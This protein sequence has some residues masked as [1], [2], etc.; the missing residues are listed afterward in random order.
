MHLAY[1]FLWQ[2]PN[3]FSFPY[4]LLAKEEMLPIG[5]FVTSGE[6]EIQLERPLVALS[7]KAS[8]EVVISVHPHAKELESIYDD[9]HDSQQNGRGHG[10]TRNK[11]MSDALSAVDVILYGD[12]QKEPIHLRH[13]HKLWM[14]MDDLGNNINLY[15]LSD[16]KHATYSGVTIIN[17]NKALTIVGVKWLP[18]G[19][20][21]FH[22]GHL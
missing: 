21:R 1:F 20:L 16:D 14:D 7:N 6:Y 18:A 8:L 13:Q 4:Y 12:N 3:C 15:F 22:L 10:E 2:I 11:F 17:R 19:D 9:V 5:E